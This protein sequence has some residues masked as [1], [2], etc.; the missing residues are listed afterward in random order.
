MRTIGLQLGGDSADFPPS[1]A[2]AGADA[3]VNH[4]V[5]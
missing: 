3:A 1:D 5:K 4:R 2:R